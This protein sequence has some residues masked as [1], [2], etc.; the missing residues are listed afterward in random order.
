[1][2][3]REG[4]K[5]V[6]VLGRKPAECYQIAKLGKLAG[7]KSYSWTFNQIKN[8]HKEGILIMEKK[9]MANFCS[10]NLENPLTFECLSYAE[11]IKFRNKK[12]PFEEIKEIFNLIPEK[13]FTLII[14]GSYANG[15][16]RKESDLDIVVIADEKANTKEIL[17][18]LLE[19]GNLMLPKIHPYVFRKTEFLGMLLSK[20]A[21]YG[22]LVE[23]N[24]IIAFGAANYYLIL[25]EAIEHGF[26]G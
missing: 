12:L 9:G 15:T 20:E 3:T 17:N 23:R 26:D 25:K 13:Y 18:I 19:K 4:A 2:L 7:K 24:R 8:L 16:A 10:L 5:I 21:N 14:T 1:M 11:A 22:K 6:E